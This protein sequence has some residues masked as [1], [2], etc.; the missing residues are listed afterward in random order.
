VHAPD[1]PLSLCKWADRDA[2]QVGDIVTIF[3]RYT[4]HGGRPIT[5]IGV[6]DSLTGRLEYVAGSAVSDRDAV[7]TATPNEAGSLTLR[8]EIDGTLQAG[9]SGV[10]RF[11]VKVK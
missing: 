2:A 4:N 8:W 10:V 9:E 11:Q 1:K 7:F 3:L 5:N 6:T